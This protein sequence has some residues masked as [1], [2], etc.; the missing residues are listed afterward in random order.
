[1]YYPGNIAIFCD[2][3]SSF[4]GSNL[5][6]LGWLRLLVSFRDFTGH[7]PDIPIGRAT[8]SL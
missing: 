1:M 8:F 7:P 4:K 6:L 3:C 5:I 2:L